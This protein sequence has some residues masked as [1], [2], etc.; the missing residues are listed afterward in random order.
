MSTQFESA[1]PSG[2]VSF[3]P[4]QGGPFHGLRKAIGLAPDQGLGL[5]RRVLTI[6]A[7]A[8]LPVVVGAIVAG[9]AME[10]GA[11]DP[12]LRHFGVHARFLVAVPLLIFAEALMQKL[13]PPLISHF[14]SSGL[15]DSATLPQ[16]RAALEH[17]RS[18]R[19]SIWGSVF[20]LAAIGVAIALSAANT[21]HA[22]EMSWAVSG[23]A[24]NA[25]MSFAGWWYV[26][27]S[28]PIFIGL[29][30]IWVWRIVVLWSLV[31]R[32]SKLDLRLVSSHPDRVGGL[33][34]LEGAAVACAPLVFAVSAVLA[35]RWA[36]EVMYHGRHVDSLKPLVAVF[37]VLAVVCFNGPLLLIGRNL[38]AFKRV[39]LLEYSSL[40]GRHGQ[41]VY[42][43][44]IRHQDVGS[45]EIM[46]APE[47]G[48][49][50]DVITIYEAVAKMRPVPLSKRSLIPIIA[51]AVLPI[52]PVFA[53]E[54]PI[55]E[56]L[57]SLA[58]ALI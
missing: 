11:A 52:L 28:R 6:V 55:K 7:V 34:F 53:M 24:G 57:K 30:S 51:A 13:I 42:Q 23:P 21:A 14:V 22:D 18:V 41:L 26:A 5:G 4:V 50:A 58:G 20:V 25:G 33:G 16:F 1:A 8:W 47:L 32:L 36:H 17:A 38:R 15:V 46:D 44:W 19:D 37:A 49:T 31:S 54:V 9:Q 27:V 29:L 10:G 2:D 12:L 48:P 56:L 40:V 45:P 43:K 39:S 3:S 35:G